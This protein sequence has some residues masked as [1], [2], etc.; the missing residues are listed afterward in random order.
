MAIRHIVFDIGN[1]FL[2]FEP[3]PAYLDLIPDQAERHVFLRDAC[4]RFDF[5]DL[6]RGMTV[7][8]KISLLKPEP[9]IFEHH[10][11]AF[12]LVP[13]ATVFIDD[14]AANVAGARKAGR[15]SLQFAGPD[16]LRHDLRLLDVAV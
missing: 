8:G 15:H 6:F 11:T 4:E 12:G 2:N 3:E 16:R 10:A 5:F 7:S 14:V 13:E 9:E 1:V